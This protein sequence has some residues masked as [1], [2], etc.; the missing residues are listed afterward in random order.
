MSPSRRTFQLGV[1]KH[2]IARAEMSEELRFH[3]DARVAHLV[4][5]GMSPDAARDEAIRR[6]G[7]TY[8]DTERHLGDSAILKERRLDVRDRLHD[9][10]DDT[11]YA[12][13]GLV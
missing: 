4:A 1:R 7:D 8:A 13:R 3:L 10:V 5:R 6:L 11:R 12:I 9:L 2:R